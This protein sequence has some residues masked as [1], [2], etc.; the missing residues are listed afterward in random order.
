MTDSRPPPRLPNFPAPPPRSAPLS[1]GPDERNRLWRLSSARSSPLSN[2]YLLHYPAFTVCRHRSA[3][4]A[5]ALCVAIFM[6][7]RRRTHLGC[8]YFVSRTAAP[9]FEIRQHFTLFPVHAGMHLAPPLLRDY[10]GCG[11]KKREGKGAR[12]QSAT[13]AGDLTIRP[14]AA[15]NHVRFSD[16][17]R[18]PRAGGKSAWRGGD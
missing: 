17:P 13:T 7:T 4:S 15:S 18:Q 11:G 1:S 5:T 8:L 16:W 12:R 14:D 3:P 9:P 2:A 6:K 10:G